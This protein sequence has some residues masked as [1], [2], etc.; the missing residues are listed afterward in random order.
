VPVKLGR[1][2]V[3]LDPE[4]TAEVKVKSF[5]SSVD[6]SPSK[7]RLFPLFAEESLPVNAEPVVTLPMAVIVPPVPVAEM[8]MVSVEASVV[9]VVP[10][11]AT[12]VNVSEVASVTT[13]D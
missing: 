13:F 9:M 6:P 8:V 3:L 2:I 11:P 5:A 10:D 12:K 1:V 4:I 7:T